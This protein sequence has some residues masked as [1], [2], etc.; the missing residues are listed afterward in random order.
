MGSLGGWEIAIVVVII[1]LVFG[2]WFIPRLGRYLGR[3]LKGL[4]EGVKEGEQGFKTAIKEDTK[5]ATKSD[6]SIEDSAGNAQK[7]E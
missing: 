1:F 5:S 7:G 3:S 6:A 4:K 2:G